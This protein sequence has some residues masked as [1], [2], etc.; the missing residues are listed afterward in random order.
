MSELSAQKPNRLCQIFAIDLRAMA[1][2][3]IAMS[4]V[5][6][7]D[8]LHR[9]WHV[10][11]LYTDNGIMPRAGLLEEFGTMMRW[12]TLHYYTS[13]NVWTQSIPLAIAVAAGVCLFVGY[14][15]FWSTL[16]TYGLLVSLHRRLPASSYGGDFILRV[17]LFWCLFLPI[18]ARWSVDALKRRTTPISNSYCSV[19]TG[20]ALLQICYMYWFTFLWKFHPDWFQGT[21]V[22]HSLRLDNYV[23]PFGV[24]IERYEP[25]TRIATYA[26]LTVE[27]LVPLAALSPVFNPYLRVAAIGVMWGLH[28][29]IELSLDVGIFSYISFACWL[30]FLPTEFFDAL[31]H[32]YE[33]T[34]QVIR[35]ALSRAAATIG[36]RS[37]E[38]EPSTLGKSSKGISIL[39][40]ALFLF[41]TA[42]NILGLPW[43]NSRG[44]S[45]PRPFVQAAK[46]IRLDQR[47]AM[48]APTPN[49]MDG[50]FTMP[51][52]LVDGTVV[53]IW[54]NNEPPVFDKPERIRYPS[55]QLR[56]IMLHH[57]SRRNSAM[58]LWFS[59]YM[60]RKWDARHDDEKHV[61]F[62]QIMYVIEP[63]GQETPSYITNARYDAANDTL[64]T[65]Q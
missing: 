30:L 52:Q 46:L 23:R 16:V 12:T 31:G 62:L 41:V 39:V 51:C 48:F 34:T 40:T 61:R 50:W 64:L 37:E 45:M 35:S 32:R 59:R 11:T 10:E 3:R 38:A 21:A 13:S 24:W 2:F 56:Q 53:D 8:L 15:T 22:G 54:Q 55:T 6:L 4:T 14:K 1:L 65:N 18:G 63:K 25:I 9:W 19:A 17:M 26:T 58:W 20:V 42:Y 28:L 5:L 57:R 33:N 60:V 47:W 43:L 49:I 7:Y 36:L 44:I 29:G 27:S